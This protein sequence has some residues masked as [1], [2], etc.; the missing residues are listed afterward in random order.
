MVFKAR[1]PDLKKIGILKKK[2]FTKIVTLKMIIQ[3]YFFFVKKTCQ[4]NLPTKLMEKSCKK[5]VE[6]QLFWPK[7]LRMVILRVKIMGNQKK[8]EIPKKGW[9]RALK[10]IVPDFF[11]LSSDLFPKSKSFDIQ[12]TM[13]I[14]KLLRFDF[15]HTLM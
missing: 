4:R 10:N 5:R 12:I 11:R 6:N 1:K 8:S 7:I 13:P 9:D 15:S 2:L 3:K 14:I